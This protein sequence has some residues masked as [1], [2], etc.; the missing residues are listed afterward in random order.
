VADDM[1]TVETFT[2]FGFVA[3]WAFFFGLMHPTKIP[4]FLAVGAAVSTL[5][6]SLADGRHLLDL[7][8]FLSFGLNFRHF[9]TRIFL[10]Q[11]L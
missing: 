4:I 9:Q 11:N 2:P 3:D 1:P 6:D 10:I 7:F 8:E 5:F